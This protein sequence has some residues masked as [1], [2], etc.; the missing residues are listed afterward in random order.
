MNRMYTAADFYV[1]ECGFSIVPL[2]ERSKARLFGGTVFD[3]K[4]PDE[5]HLK[6]WYVQTKKPYNIAIVPGEISGNLVIL[7]FDEPGSFEAWHSATGIETPRVIS[8]RGVHVYV[9]LEQMIRNGKGYFQGKKF[10][11]IIAHGNITAP[12]SVHPSGHEY[13][14]EGNPRT[15]PLF[16][17][18]ASLSVERRNPDGGHSTPRK[19]MPSPVL[20]RGNVYGVDL[21]YDNQ[22]KPI[23]NKQAYIM[24]AVRQ[25]CEKVATCPESSHNRNNTLYRAALNLAKFVNVAPQGM[26][27]DELHTAALRSGMNEQADSITATIR[28]GL[29]TGIERGVLA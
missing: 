14:W 26:I 6:N 5:K 24:S 3:Q 22:G 10:G 18:L 25:E 11:D 1:R 21:E 29:R 4:K 12:P 7:D 15:V 20:S 9:R 27:E 8:R 16:P 2:H 13:R 19:P 28:S 23:K 17:C